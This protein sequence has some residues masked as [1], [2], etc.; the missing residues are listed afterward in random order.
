MCR[1]GRPDIL[2]V[3][4]AMKQGCARFFFLRHFINGSPR[5]D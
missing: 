1:R 4:F 2:P 3:H 5:G